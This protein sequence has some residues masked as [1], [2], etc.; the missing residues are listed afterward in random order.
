M[1][2]RDEGKSLGLLTIFNLSDQHTVT[3]QANF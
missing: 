1:G 2:E 3:R